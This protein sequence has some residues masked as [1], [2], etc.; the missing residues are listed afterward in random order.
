MA[1]TCG[2]TWLVRVRRVCCC[3]QVGPAGRP[4]A[5][6]HTKARKTRCALGPHVISVP[7]DRENIARRDSQ[8]TGVT[9]FSGSSGLSWVFPDPRA[10][11]RRRGRPGRAHST[12]ILREN[13][14]TVKPWEPSFCAAGGFR[15]CLRLGLR[16]W[17]WAF[18]VNHWSYWSPQFE[19]CTSGGLGISRCNWTSPRIR[20][21]PSTGR[22]APQF[23]VSI[24]CALITCSLW[25]HSTP[26]GWV[27]GA[28]TD[29]SGWPAMA[30]PR[31]SAMP[32]S[33]QP[34]L[35][36][37]SRTVDWLIDVSD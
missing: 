24:H 1:P 17:S 35:R 6:A 14:S 30:P 33:G 16:A 21:S 8:L 26:L 10:Y 25:W 34:G 23:P 9:N 3:C 5:H 27:W 18:A 13:S 20:C 32:Q 15:L 4:V 28:R 37:W 31:P 19:L 7:H 29:G 22:V 11:I 36:N 2:P 12:P